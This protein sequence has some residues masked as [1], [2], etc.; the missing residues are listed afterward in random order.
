MLIIDPTTVATAIQDPRHKL[1]RYARLTLTPELKG[2]TIYSKLE[3][4]GDLA[5]LRHTTPPWVEQYTEVGEGQLGFRNIGIQHDDGEG[6]TQGVPEHDGF[7]FTFHGS[8]A[9]TVALDPNTRQIL[10]EAQAQIQEE[11]FQQRLPRYT[12]WDFKLA[13]LISTDGPDRRARL[14][15]SNEEQRARAEEKYLSGQGQ[16]LQIQKEMFEGILKM[17]QANGGQAVVTAES[18]KEV[19]EK[20]TTEGLLPDQIAALDE[21][22][23]ANDEYE[24]ERAM[25]AVAVPEIDVRPG[26]KMRA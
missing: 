15:E 20:K 2:M 11:T 17:I 14:M 26:R 1:D 18:L 10:S 21:L 8:P 12:Q 19:V 3:S 25:G 24:K 23:K 16:M 22:Q 6:P 7:I 5:D 4:Q 13:E 9:G